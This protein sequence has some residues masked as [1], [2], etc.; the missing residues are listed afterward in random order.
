MICCPPVRR[1]VSMSDYSKETD[2]RNEK[3][4]REL[5]RELPPYVG[6]YMTGVSQLTASRTRLAYAYDL[7][8]FF[9]FLKEKNPRLKNTEIREIPIEV[10]Q[11][12]NAFDFDDYMAY[13]KLHETETASGRVIEQ[14]NERKGIKRKLS[15]VRSMYKFLYRRMMIDS[16]PSEL[17]DAPKIRRSREIIALDQEEA[18]DLLS[19]VET[20][21]GLT[22][23][24]LQYHDKTSL[25]DTAIVTL[26]LGTGI[27]VSECVGLDIG[28]VNLKASQIEIMRKGGKKAFVYIGDAVEA[29]LADYLEERSRMTP[30]PGSEQA[31]FLSLQNRRMA[32]RSVE[33]LVKKYATVSVQGKKITPHKL[34]SSYGTNLYRDT[35]DLLLT[36]EALGHENVQTTRDHYVATSNEMLYAVR[37]KTLLQDDEDNT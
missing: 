7:R 22:A 16:N 28:D 9:R 27:R 26:L 29:V 13:L 25:R 30:E 3:K 32:V 34:R 37:N 12:L 4:L 23:K 33:R 15:A 1:G 35:R 17:V 2:I 10:L 19:S 21:N 36:S 31:L 14:T 6:T 11:Q 18:S 5:L 8:I 20:G 24:M